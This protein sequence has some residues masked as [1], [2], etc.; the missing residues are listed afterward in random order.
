M[1]FGLAVNRSY[2]IESKEAVHPRIVVDDYVAEQVIEY[3][4]RLLLTNWQSAQMVKQINGS[5]VKMDADGKYMMHYLN[6]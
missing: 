4:N 6:Q 3:N 5:I 1:F 2:Q